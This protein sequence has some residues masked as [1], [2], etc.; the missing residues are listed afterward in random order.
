MPVTVAIHR[1]KDFDAWIDTFKENPPPPVGRWRML[2]GTDDP[3]R[4]HIVGEM[5]A[6]EVKTVKD[7]LASARMQEVFNRVNAMSTA[8]IE[9]IWL[10]EQTP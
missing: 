4:V 1:L 8:P 2:R 9:F 3:N 5:A 10:E 7:F 6:S